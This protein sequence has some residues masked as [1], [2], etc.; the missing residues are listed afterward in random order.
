MIKA[1]QLPGAVQPI[2]ILIRG[3]LLNE[4]HHIFH[5][6]PQGS[7]E[8]SDGLL[9]PLLKLLS[10]L[11]RSVFGRVLGNHGE[12]PFFAPDFVRRMACKKSIEIFI[13]ILYSGI[14]KNAKIILQAH[15]CCERR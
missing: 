12:E 5:P 14:R 9:D 3:A 1:K 11:T 10:A 2:P 7:R 13:L 8:Q 15:F 6:V 4:D